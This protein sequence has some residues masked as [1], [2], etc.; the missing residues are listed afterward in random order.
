MAEGGSNPMPDNRSHPVRR[1]HG[2]AADG[3]VTVTVSPSGALLGVHV[4]PGDY[5]PQDPPGLANMGDMV[6]E[7]LCD[8]RAR[9][10]AVTEGLCGPDESG[11]A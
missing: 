3:L 5:Q 8:A 6:V 9:A 10:S 1:I 11:L 2:C 4:H 7:A